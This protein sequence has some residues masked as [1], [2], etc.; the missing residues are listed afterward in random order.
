L[1]NFF[2]ILFYFWFSFVHFGSGGVHC[3]RILAVDIPIVIILPL[4]MEESELSS[5][6]NFQQNCTVIIN[7]SLID[8][9]GV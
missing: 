7:I 5:K 8:I 4:C 6:S 3:R 2:F 9:Q 1:V